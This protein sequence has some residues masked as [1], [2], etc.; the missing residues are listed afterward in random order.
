M[1]DE[2][3]E[4]FIQVLLSY[5]ENPA[6]Q[7]RH[8]AVTTLLALCAKRRDVILKLIPKLKDPVSLVKDAVKN[9]LQQVAGE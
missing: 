9:T 4:R 7:I 8:Y 1:S 6:G 3:Y 2:L 5:L